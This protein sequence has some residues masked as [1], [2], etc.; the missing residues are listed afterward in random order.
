VAITIKLFLEKDRVRSVAGRN[1]IYPD[2]ISQFARSRKELRSTAVAAIV[3]GLIFIISFFL[4]KRSAPHLLLMA[5]VYIS[6]LLCLFSSVRTIVSSIA[7]K[8]LR[9]ASKQFDGAVKESG[10]QFFVEKKPITVNGRVDSA[11][12]QLL[13][14]ENDTI[15]LC[16]KY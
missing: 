1:E 2:L 7:L 11:S 8:R 12:H 14:I 5:T 13:S 10:P 16:R 4:S 3:A 9:E 6:M 15:H